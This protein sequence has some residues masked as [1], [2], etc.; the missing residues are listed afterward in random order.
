MDNNI[1]QE[2]ET[3]YNRL[4]KQTRRASTKTTETFNTSTTEKVLP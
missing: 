3:D 2:M 4:N 1:H